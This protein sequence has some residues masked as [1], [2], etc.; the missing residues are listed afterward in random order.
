MK[1]DRTA[2]PACCKCVRTD[3]SFQKV[4]NVKPELVGFV[5]TAAQTQQAPLSFLPKN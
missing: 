4:L 5:L 1:A 2:E 3:A